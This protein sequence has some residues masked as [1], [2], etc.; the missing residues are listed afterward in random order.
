[1]IFFFFIWGIYLY[2]DSVFGQTSKDYQAT[3]NLEYEAR[4]GLKGAWDWFIG[5][6]AKEDGGTS[7]KVPWYLK[8]WFSMGYRNGK[9]GLRPK[10]R[11]L[12]F[13]LIYLIVMI[14]F[15]ILTG[16]LI[17]FIVGAVF[18]SKASGGWDQAGQT[19]WNQVGTPG[20]GDSVTIQNTHVVFSESNTSCTTMAINAGGTFNTSDGTDWDF[21]MSGTM[22][23][24][25]GTFW[26][27]GSTISIASGLNGLYGI[28]FA[29]GGVYEGS[30]G[31]NPTGMHTLGSM[32]AS[33]A[34]TL[35][36]TTETTI[37]NGR[38]AANL[39]AFG[40]R[41]AVAFD[42][43]NG[44]V[45]FTYAGTQYFWNDNNGPLTLYDLEVDKTGANKFQFF[46]GAGFNLIVDNDFTITSGFYDSE[47]VGGTDWDLRVNGATSIT[48][49]LDCNSNT[50]VME[51]N[52][53]INGGGV[54]N[55]DGSSITL[56]TAGSST[57]FNNTGTVNVG[58]AT[59]YGANASWSFI[60]TGNDWNW[61]SAGGTCNLKWFDFQFDITT[62]GGGIKL[63]MDG[64]G[65]MDGI[66]ITAN[67]ELDCN[68]H[69]LTFSGDFNRLGTW[70]AGTGAVVLNGTSQTIND[71]NTW[72]GFTKSVAA[73]D[74]LTFEASTTQTFGGT[75]NLEGAM[76]EL[77]SLV[78]DTP[79]TTW[80]I[81]VL[82]GATKGNIRYLSITDSD[83]SPSDATQKPIGPLFSTDGGNN[84]DWF[85]DAVYQ[86]NILQFTSIK[87]TDKWFPVR[88]MDV[89]H[90]GIKTVAFDEIEVEYFEDDDSSWTSYNVL[91]ANWKEIGNGYYS[92]QMG[93]GEFV[94]E[95]L[96]YTV[97]VKAP[98]TA[99]EFY[100]FTVDVQLGS[101]T[102]IMGTSF[103]KDTDSLVQL[104]HQ[105]GTKG[106]DAI[107]DRVDQLSTS[108]APVNETASSAVITN[109]TETSGTY[110]NTAALDGVYHEITKDGGNIID[111]YYEFI[112]PGDAVP[113]TV[114][115]T[116]RVQIATDDLDVDAYNWVT[117]GWQQ[118]GIKNGVGPAV[119]TAD[120]YDLFTSMVG[121]GADLGK[122]RIR[123]NG[124]GLTSGVLSTDQ[125]FVSYS[126]LGRSAGYDDGAIWID[127]L[128]GV[129]GTTTWVNGVAD[130]PVDSIADALTLAAALK[131][132]RFRIAPGSSITF[133]A[134][135]DGYALI[136]KHWD[137]DLGSQD[138]N[139]TIIVG[140]NVEGI[141]TASSDPHFEDCCIVTATTLPPCH[142]HKCGLGTDIKL[143]G[144]GHYVW[145][146]C[147]SEIPGSGTPA[148]DFDDIGGVE[149]CLRHG[150]G[151][152]EIKKM[153]AGDVMSYE[154]DGQ[155]VIAASCNGGIVVPR[156]NMSYTDNAA[157]AVT[158]NRDAILN[159][160]RLLTAVEPEFTNIKGTGHIKDVDSLVNLT[161]EK[162]SATGSVVDEG[163][164]TSGTWQDTL[165]DD[166]NY[167]V[168]QGQ[169]GGP[170]QP[171]DMTLRMLTVLDVNDLPSKVHIKG[172][173][174]AGGVR[175]VNVSIW[176]Y[177][178]R[179]WDS[180]GAMIH[181]TEDQEYTYDIEDNNYINPSG[182]EVRLR[183]MDNGDLE[184]GD[185]LRL[186]YIFFTKNRIGTIPG[187]EVKDIT[188]KIIRAL[189]LLWENSYEDNQVYNEKSQQTSGRVRIYDSA[190]NATT[191]GSTGLIATYT[192]TFTYSGNLLESQ[193]VVIS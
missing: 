159:Q 104:S 34:T 113:S 60:A 154:A 91:T 160:E 9:F 49:T 127:T 115:H 186:N 65:E 25:A 165:S 35:R 182:G 102:S 107:H 136:G 146:Q 95:D 11:D 41:D 185:R 90:D 57:T 147:F 135:M 155:L 179:V 89:D 126:V 52:V 150:S 162:V 131:L 27:N 59:I 67:D 133:A 129:A 87:A 13:T 149:I 114:T 18:T 180:L 97:V 83:A 134:T 178:T 184:S 110:A 56:G 128:D 123:F 158:V 125:I 103:V 143:G 20:V 173:M 94:T 161:P 187:K 139:N 31:V 23:S 46:N 37:F 8:T 72:Y 68:T 32:N 82:V 28:Q 183:F 6:R 53:T 152:M 163:S 171:Y 156:G 62:G 100:Q 144:A 5:I 84:T 54:L 42:N 117:P 30:S 71:T 15:Y 36:L 191:H 40:I 12:L 193:L 55:M 153:A 79:A 122:V 61:D 112:I 93:A 166:A 81:N 16:I 14:I 169:F 26:T 170:A 157:G 4:T 132:K 24:L 99:S 98:Q 177:D 19:T 78:S 151:G 174:D 1:M 172:Y 105:A 74:T 164:E 145:D 43:G 58:T 109:G 51:G 101:L 7:M 111:M 121:T 86:D 140:A 17:P 120:T 44:L 10:W 176:N 50:T 77:L 168:L 39:I 148:I 76:G 75:L 33:T 73:A 47:E 142:M 92:L 189:G 29:A 85:I 106:T 21:T 192:F 137:L 175:Q 167:Y 119:D 190:A 181:N 130:N 88:L 66:T 2:D 3:L 22:T 64:D 124:T 138:I 80:S 96:I 70:T 69:T 63:D 45:K 48:G 38:R 118:V 188:D 141:G 108:G 116:G